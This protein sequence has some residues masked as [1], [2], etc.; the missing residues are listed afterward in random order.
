MIKKNDRPSLTELAN[1]FGS[2]KGTNGPSDHW[3]A[4]NYTDVYAAYL[5]PLRDMPVR[6]LEIGI[7]SL[8]DRWDARIVH[9][10]N[11]GGASIKM[12]EAYFPNAEIVAIDI[13]PAE[14][15]D[16]NRV[17]TFVLDQSSESEL[18]KFIQEQECF[19]IIIDDGSHNPEHQQLSL[20]ILFSKLNNGGLYII[21]DLDNNGKEDLSKDDRA[22]SKNVINTR[23]VLKSLIKTNEPKTPHG[24]HS[25]EFLDQID[26]I[27]FHCPEISAKAQWQFL[28][29]RKRM[30]YIFQEDTE[31]VCALRK[32]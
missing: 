4:L 5:E 18:T 19:D 12:W 14:Y 20:S 22:H 21:E 11:K 8:G 28:P 23:T 24:F 32:V 31:R 27:S 15:L 10:R 30:S 3:Q 7:G 13:N 17:Q 29:P 25:S 2:D 16:S 26:Q 1:K 6:L 9:G